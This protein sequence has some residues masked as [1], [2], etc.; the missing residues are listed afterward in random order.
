MKF[1]IIKELNNISLLEKIH[2][3][4]KEIF[5]LRIQYSL[6][7]LKNTKK[8]SKLKKDIARVKTL[9]TQRNNNKEI[10]NANKIIS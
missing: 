8:I 2:N 3:A 5:E 9:L 7:K 4:K 10:I 1:K 6:N